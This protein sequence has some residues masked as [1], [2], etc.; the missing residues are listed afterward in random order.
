VIQRVRRLLAFSPG[1]V[2]A[3]GAE[4]LKGLGDWLQRRQAWVRCLQWGLVV[5]Y[6]TLLFVPAIL[7]QP[8]DRADALSSLAGVAEI[9]FWGFWWPAV[10]LSMMLFGQFWCGVLCPDGALTEW[11]SRH[12]KAGKI[13]AWVR[14]GGWPLLFF[15]DTPEL[16]TLG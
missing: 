8:A 7:P 12:G 4:L 10:I 3:R 9:I 1:A 16:R 11:A 13:S 15:F 5:C 2:E 6:Y 14:W